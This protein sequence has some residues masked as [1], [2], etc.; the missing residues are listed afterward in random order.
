MRS[1]P[2]KSWLSVFAMASL[3]ATRAFAQSGDPARSPADE[4]MRRQ[5]DLNRTQRLDALE[6]ATPDAPKA[7]APPQAEGEKG[8]CFAITHVEVEGVT[9]LPQAALAPVLERYQNS[10]IGLADISALLKGLTSLYVDRG[11]VA[12]RFYVPA[13]DIAATKTLRLVAAEGSLSDIYLNGKA[14]A[15]DS[16]LATAFPGLRGKPVNIRD[17]EQGLD[18][19]NRLPSNNA[20]TA[21]LPGAQPGQ[22]ILNVENKPDKPWHFSV[23]NNNLGQASTGYSQSSLTLGIDNLFDLNDL[24]S[25]SYQHTGPDY[26][27]PDDGVGRSNSISGSFG[28]PY[29]YWTLGLSGSWYRYNSMIPGNFSD[30]ETS[31]DSGQFGISLDRVLLRDKASIT[32][33]NA[34]LNYKQTDNF[35]M[36]NRIEVGSRQYTVGSI[37]ISHSRRMLGGVWVFDLGYSQGLDMFDAVRRGDPAAADADPEFSKFSATLN[38]TTPFEI[39]GQK[40]QFAT[41][42]NGQYSPDNL[43]GAEQMSLG[44]YS[45]V[46]GTRDSILFGN[47]GVFTHNELVWRTQ[48]WAENAL[49]AERLGELRPYAGIDYGHVF[50]QERFDI[51]TGDIASWTVGSRLAGGTVNA[52]LGYS[53]IFKSTADATMRNLFFMSASLQF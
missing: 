52:D 11:Y 3:A 22:S 40:L 10:C 44:G 30:I 16:T 38:V 50:G 39:S 21:M 49:L 2:L 43:F 35:L 37:G 23:A 31:G 45:N 25:L 47:N 20:K 41:L 18:Q 36:G 6:A 28:V 15:S 46:R 9:L 7:K 12:S 13:Q 48:P 8:P 34:A 24:I 4:F 1:I 29:G 17:V 14:A 42:V 51:E 26:P 19:I 33:L 32:T 53:H 27:W 5:S